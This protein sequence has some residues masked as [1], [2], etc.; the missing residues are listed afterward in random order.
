MERERGFRHIN[1]VVGSKYIRLIL[2]STA[3]KCF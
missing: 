3:T 1:V 2:Y